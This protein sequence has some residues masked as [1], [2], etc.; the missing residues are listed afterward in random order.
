MRL[1]RF[2]ASCQGIKRQNKNESTDD[3]AQKSVSGAPERQLASSSRQSQSHRRVIGI[4]VF[5]P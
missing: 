5:D 4:A 3:A 1:Q 2:A